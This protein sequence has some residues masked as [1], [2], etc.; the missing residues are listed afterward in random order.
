VYRITK[1]IKA[2]SNQQKAVEPLIN[3]ECISLQYIYKFP[4]D[5]I[6]VQIKI[7][8]KIFHVQSVLYFLMKNMG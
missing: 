2:A 3:D 4:D 6:L 8:N 1:L 5:K 7:D